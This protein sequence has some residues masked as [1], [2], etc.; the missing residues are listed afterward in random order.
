M[1]K[2]LIATLAIALFGAAGSAN[3][4]TVVSADI[5]VDTTFSGTV[6][7]TAPIF[8]T[9]DAVL[10]I[11]P[12]TIVRG[13]PRTAAPA[14]GV[15]AGTPGTLL[16]TQSGSIN[17]VGTAGSPIIMTTAAVDRNGNGIAD[18]VGGDGSDTFLLPWVPADGLL[19]FYD[20]TPLAAP[21]SPL[22]PA[23][24]AN[25]QMWGGLVVLGEAPTNLNDVQGIGKGLATIEGITIPGFPVANATYGGRNAWDCSGALSFISVRHAG[26]EIGNANELNGVTLGGVG[27]G[28][29]MDHI[30][31]YAN[32]D[33]G[34]EWFGGTVNGMFLA[35]IM[36]GDDSFDVDQGYVGFN[37]FLLNVSAF[38]TTNVDIVA[39]AGLDP[40]G[41]D[42]SDKV[43]EWDGDDCPADCNVDGEGFT[44]PTPSACFFNLTSFGTSVN[45]STTGAAPEFVVGFP[46]AGET[47]L[48]MRNGFAGGLFNSIITNSA[49]ACDT[50]GIDAL[51][52]ILS[53]TFVDNGGTE[54]GVD[55]LD[56]IGNAIADAK[57]GGGSPFTDN[58]S[59]GAAAP[60][61]TPAA[62][63]GFVNEDNSFDPTGATALGAGAATA[64]K[65]TPALKSAVFDPRPVPAALRSPR[66]SSRSG[67]VARRHPPARSG[68][69]SQAP[70]RSGF[71]GSRAR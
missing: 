23:G 56:I 28:T 45:S 27:A 7:L 46:N 43:G 25:V 44:T 11:L 33:D 35:V 5:T 9:S 64:G 58:C 21:L 55:G 8:V 66:R 50:D 57:V 17:A 20:D 70:A 67:S 42:S 13:Q 38:F 61:T 2:T 29:Q 60:N 53:N 18:R 31:V 14:P 22:D 71:R 26:D 62:F 49:E 69:A 12:G 68:G 30:E 41:S 47:A 6:I 34:I 10:T 40:Y 19:A 16:V 3:A 37:Q 63:A 52:Q 24:R 15:T 65:L 48:N 39:P 4:Q 32:Q 36:T 59:P 51:T 54:C 1:R